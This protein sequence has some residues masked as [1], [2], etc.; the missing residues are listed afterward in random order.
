[1]RYWFGTPAVPLWIARRFTRATAPSA[2]V[3]LG[4]GLFLSEQ[5]RR[6][7]YACYL[8]HD[9]TGCTHS[10]VDR[11]GEMGG[12]LGWVGRTEFMLLGTCLVVVGLF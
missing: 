12:V 3:P 2:V 9:E 1:M 10:L 4:T 11:A 8:A 6:A 5:V 7:S